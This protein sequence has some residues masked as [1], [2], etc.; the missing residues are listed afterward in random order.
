M[1]RMSKA[2]KEPDNLYMQA[3]NQCHGILKLHRSA[4]ERYT[5]ENGMQ[6]N[7]HKLLLTLSRLGPEACQRDLAESMHITP[8]AV[9]VTLKKLEKAG[10]VEKKISE[11]D[12]RY[13]RIIITE[14]GEKIV[15]ESYDMFRSIDTQAFEGFSEEEMKQLLGYLERVREN[16]LKLV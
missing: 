11:K 16:F 12:N 1:P 7:Q 9:A 4:I 13:N 15:K 2:K 6:K 14:K 3:L 5:E 10:I 8:A